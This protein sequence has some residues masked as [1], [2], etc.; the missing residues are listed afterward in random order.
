MTSPD[1]DSPTGPITRPRRRV[2]RPVGGTAPSPPDGDDDV[3]PRSRRADRRQAPSPRGHGHGHG[4]GGDGS[5]PARQVRTVLVAVL[6]PLALAVIVGLVLLAPSPAQYAQVATNARANPDTSGAA[7]AASE[8]SVDGEVRRASA[9]VDC[10]D[11]NLP[12]SRPGAGCVALTVRL[13]AGPAAGR[14]ITLPVPTGGGAPRFA[15]GDGVVLAWSGTAPDDPSSYQVQDYQ[16]GVPLAVL[17]VLFAAA[18]IALGRWQ[19]LASLASLGVT[20]GVLALFVLPALLVGAN[21]VAVALVAAGL[22]VG[23]VF[24]L[25]HGPSAR[26]ATAALGTLASLAL[27]GVIAIAF[28]G[29]ARLTG[30][31][32][33]ATDLVGV[34]GPGIDTRGILL[35]GV[36]IGALGV[37]DDITVTQTS[38]VWELHRADP[39]S[40]L[41]DLYGSAMRVGRDHVASAVNTLVL[42]Y[43]G[44]ALPLLLLFSLGGR[45]LGDILTAEDVAQEVLRTL[46]GSI[47]IVAAVPVTTILAAL[48]VRSV[49]G[50]A[51]GPDRPRRPRPPRPSRPPGAPTRSRDVPT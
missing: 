20:L 28:A 39:T 38:T 19:G 50:H 44:A 21:P 33:D 11:P 4:H 30:L 6:A 7:A 34:V 26:T 22:T 43:A 46:A 41:R 23:V 2:D 40:G 24:P 9:E 29:F 25:T 27:I 5:A 31:D 14:E 45:G 12:V 42:A 16:R 15:V 37:L 49:S 3:E 32:N 36:I 35:A 17:G 18:V 48:V 51:G 8:Q 10:G 47:G 13:D 1:D